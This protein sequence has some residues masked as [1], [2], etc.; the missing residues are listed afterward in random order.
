[1]CI[2][3]ELMNPCFVSTDKSNNPFGA[4]QML[5]NKDTN[6]APRQSGTFTAEPYFLIDLPHEFSVCLVSLSA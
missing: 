1:M 5:F 6:D 4:S 3:W 2:H